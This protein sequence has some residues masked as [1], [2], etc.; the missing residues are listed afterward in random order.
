[1]I[2]VQNLF[3]RYV[4]NTEPVLKNISMVIHEGEYIAIIGPNGCGKTTFVRHLNGLLRPTEGEVRINEMNTRDPLALSLIRQKVGMVFQ[5]PDNQLVGMTVEEDV[6]FGPGNLNLPPAEIRRRVE[7]SLDVVGMKKYAKSPPFALSAGEKQLV[8][9]AG[10]LAMN[11]RCIVFDEP[12]AYLDPSARR[13]ILQVMR[14]LNGRGI[15]IVHVT[16]HMDDIAQA[17]RVMVMNGGTMIVNDS[18]TH[19]F[20]R[21]E[22]LKGMGLGVP[23]VTELMWK[24]REMG[25]EV[26]PHLFTVDEACNEISALLKR[27]E[28]HR[29]QS[30][31]Q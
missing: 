28:K 19:V 11:P 23:K 8:A 16:H 27:Q 22:W 29:A 30:E 6:S 17:D 3:Y 7:E 10:V 4:D 1:M 20:S 9:I 25:A 13:K 5:N 24:L 2:Q 31:A 26:N 14:E 21:V 18:P 12:T 15:T